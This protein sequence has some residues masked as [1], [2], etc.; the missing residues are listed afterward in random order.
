MLEHMVKNGIWLEYEWGI[1][2][3]LMTSD[4]YITHLSRAFSCR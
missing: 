1:R 2:G 4:D 3:I